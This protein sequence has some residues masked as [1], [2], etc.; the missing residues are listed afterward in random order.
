MEQLEPAY[1]LLSELTDADVAS[2]NPLMLQEL[3][4]TGLPVSFVTDKAGRV[5][6]SGWG[7]PTVSR[8]RQLLSERD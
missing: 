1:T 5:L 3:A 6:D 7:V 4:K 2:V 8:L